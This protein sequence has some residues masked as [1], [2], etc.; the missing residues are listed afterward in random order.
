LGRWASLDNWLGSL[1]GRV[2]ASWA[3]QPGWQ[4]RSA[5]A[6]CSMLSRSVPLWAEILCKAPVLRQFENDRLV[7]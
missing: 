5:A 6:R 4:E 7:G 1:P 3:I 2:W